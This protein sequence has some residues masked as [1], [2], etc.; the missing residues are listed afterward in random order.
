[1]LEKISLEKRGWL[2]GVQKFLLEKISVILIVINDLAFQDMDQLQQGE[3]QADAMA[4][5]M[6]YAFQS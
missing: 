2:R 6:V 3:V 4:S 5:D 1:M